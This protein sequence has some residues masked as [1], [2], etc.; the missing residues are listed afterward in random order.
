M[1]DSAQILVTTG[2]LALIT[3]TLWFFFG[4]RAE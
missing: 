4:K 2:G 1:M 3:F